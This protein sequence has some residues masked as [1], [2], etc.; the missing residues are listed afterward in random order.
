MFQTTNQTIMYNNIDATVLMIRYIWN[1]NNI[2]TYR[3][4]MIWIDGRYFYI[5]S[6]SMII[7]DYQWL[8]SILF[9]CASKLSTCLVFAPHVLNFWTTTGPGDHQYIMG[10]AC[11]KM[12]CRDAIAVFRPCPWDLY[13]HVFNLYTFDHICIYT[14]HIIPTIL[15]LK[16]T[17]YI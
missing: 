15:H 10:L 1:I 7:N 2:S 8:L 12:R 17:W 4:I 16:S 3:N 13:T 14:M 5:Q 6:E 11:T 9:P